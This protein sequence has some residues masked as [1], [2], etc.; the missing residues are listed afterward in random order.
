MAFSVQGRLVG[1]ST[2]SWDA[3][4][5]QRALR[6]PNRC[7][8]CGTE[9]DDRGRLFCDGCLPE[10]RAD[11][12]RRFATAGPAALAKLRAAGTDPAQLPEARAKL[13]ES[14]SERGLAVAAWDR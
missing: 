11:T 2:T 12:A 8:T 7:G 13:S 1:K 6:L 14:M 9:L 3:N 4:Q 5:S 10:A